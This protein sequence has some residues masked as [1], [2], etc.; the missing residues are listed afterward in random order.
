ML[1][2]AMSYLQAQATTRCGCVGSGGRQV[3]KSSAV[4]WE[5]LELVRHMRR[6]G[7]A[8]E[9]IGMTDL[10]HRQPATFASLQVV[11]VTT[12]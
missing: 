7:M 11:Q 9:M 10:L 4:I 5:L 8:Q 6:R 2:V 12:D 3:Y 1:L